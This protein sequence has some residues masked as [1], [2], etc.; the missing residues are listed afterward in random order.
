MSIL[1]YSKDEEIKEKIIEELLS[2]GFNVN[3]I[4]TIYLVDAIIY[5]INYPKTKKFKRNI[6]GCCR[7]LSNKLFGN[8]MGN[9]K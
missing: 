7:K 4:G 8:K 9:S 1:I 5:S 2:V 3:S 6:Y